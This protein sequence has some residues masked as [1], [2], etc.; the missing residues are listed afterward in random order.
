MIILID[1]MERKL[2]SDELEGGRQEIEGAD[3]EVEE[4]KHQDNP[5]YSPAHSPYLPSKRQIWKVETLEMTYIIDTFMHIY[6][7]NSIIY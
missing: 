3:E 6:A 2:T 5:N 4:A 1:A 7:E